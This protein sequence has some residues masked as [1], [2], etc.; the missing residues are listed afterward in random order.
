MIGFR[1]RPSLADPKQVNKGAP[2]GAELAS[3][4][5]LFSAVPLE[6]VRCWCKAL[7]LPLSTAAPSGVLQIASVS[8]GH[9]S[10]DPSPQTSSNKGPY[11]AWES[12][13]AMQAVSGKPTGGYCACSA[14]GLL[15]LYPVERESQK[16][17][18]RKAFRTLLYWSPGK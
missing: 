16:F 3:V 1:G 8:A 13:Y 5:S 6:P 4:S 9:M 10:N 17:P 14:S 15:N 12:R 7:R 18:P 11:S 2:P